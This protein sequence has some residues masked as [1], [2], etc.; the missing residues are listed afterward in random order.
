MKSNGLY[1]IDT[2]LKMDKELTDFFNHINADYK[3][4]CDAYSHLLGK[5]KLALNGWPEDF[6]LTPIEK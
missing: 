1:G 6:N 3:R 5:A 2:M 4:T